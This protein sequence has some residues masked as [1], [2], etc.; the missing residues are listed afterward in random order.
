MPLTAQQRMILIAPPVAVL[1]GIVLLWLCIFILLGYLDWFLPVLDRPIPSI[2]EPVLTQGMRL[3]VHSPDGDITIT[4]GNGRK[5]TYD[6]DNGSRSTELT[7]NRQ[8][9]SGNLG[10][11]RDGRWFPH[12]GI[13]HYNIHEGQLN[14]CSIEQVDEYLSRTPAFKPFVYR[15]DGL[16]AWINKQPGHL[17]IEIFQ[18]YVNS[19]KPLKLRG[20]QDE[21]IL[22]PQGEQT[23]QVT[24]AP[25]G[26][27]NEKYKPKGLWTRHRD[28]GSSHE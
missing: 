2:N 11:G 5:R 20:A 14:F 12:R 22:L 9:W 23:A 24:R 18:V 7:P 6:W 21:K 19:V 8:R 26:D 15:N 13:S 17:G 27:P 16:T 25:V 3:L 28:K 10:L 1:V 4:A